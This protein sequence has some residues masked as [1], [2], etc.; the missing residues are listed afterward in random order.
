M[1]FLLTGGPCTG[2]SSTILQLQSLGYTV[3]PEVSRSI[4]EQEQVKEKPILPWTNLYVFNELVTAKQKKL[5][6]QITDEVVFLDRGMHD[7]LVYCADGK[8][9][10]PP[11]LLRETQ[12]K[13]YDHVFLLDRLPLYVIDK[14]RKE[15]A[16]KGM[17]LH[18]G[19]EKVYKDAG[20][21]VTRVPVDSIENR[22][23]YIIDCVKRI[24]DKERDNK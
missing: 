17:R 1:K 19:F 13:R 14:E 3:V 20:Y 22:A 9:A 23:Q 16:E 18:A 21:T 15:D 12:I 4:I 8:I 24:R 5:E 7:N 11:E 10:I 2:K 6:E